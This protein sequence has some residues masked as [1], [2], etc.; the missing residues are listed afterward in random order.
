MRICRTILYSLSVTEWQYMV[1]PSEWHQLVFNLKRGG[2]Q[3]ELYSTTV[4]LQ[5]ICSK[6]CYCPAARLINTCSY[7]C[8][9]SKHY[10]R[11]LFSKLDKWSHSDLFYLHTICLS[12]L[13][14]EETFSTCGRSL[15]T[16]ATDVAHVSSVSPANRSE[17]KGWQ[18][19]HMK[20]HKESCLFTL[21]YNFFGHKRWVL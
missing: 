17:S 12:N 10:F 11:F 4:V 18:T 13:F 20:W 9:Y 16:P 2:A 14:T 21:A 19:V 8:T 15:L 1:I 5:I 3:F 6:H 7:T